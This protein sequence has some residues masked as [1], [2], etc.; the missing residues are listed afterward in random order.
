VERR[1]SDLRLPA[2]RALEED[3]FVLLRDFGEVPPHVEYS[4][5]PMGRDLA[6]HVAALGRWVHDHAGKVLA[7]REKKRTRRRALPTGS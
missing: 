7:E 6:T 4:L 3:G 1:R 2:L 5:T